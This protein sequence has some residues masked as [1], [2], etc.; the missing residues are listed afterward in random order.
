MFRLVQPAAKQL[1]IQDNT[2]QTAMSRVKFE[3]MTLVFEQAKTIY[4]LRIL[5]LYRVRQAN[6]LFHMAFH[7]QK[8]KLACHT[9]YFALSHQDLRKPAIRIAK[10][11]LYLTKHYAMMVYGGADV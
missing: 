7:I 11:F 6:F 3:P 10:L 2:N 4:A 8:R 9:L 1:P 5:L